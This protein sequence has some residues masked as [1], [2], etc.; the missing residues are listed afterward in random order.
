MVKQTSTMRKWHIVLNADLPCWS[1]KVIILELSSLGQ[2]HHC[3]TGWHVRGLE[4]R[5]GTISLHCAGT[6][7]ALIMRSRS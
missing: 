5:V 6:E 4:I 3:I 2:S 1:I 7:D